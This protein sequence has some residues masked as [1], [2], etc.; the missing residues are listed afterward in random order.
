MIYLC[1]NIR[2]V[3]VLL[4]DS[5]RNASSSPNT[6]AK[7]NKS[8]F[9]CVKP[10]DI[11]SKLWFRYKIVFY[12]YVLANNKYNIYSIPFIN[13]LILPFVIIFLDTGGP[14]RE[15]ICFYNGSRFA[16]ENGLFS[17]MKGFRTMRDV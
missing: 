8:A 10:F 9:I 5:D 7:D 1:Y 17:N 4:Y 15:N 6:V 14:G 2:V 13:Y 16:V 12:M 11:E 3:W